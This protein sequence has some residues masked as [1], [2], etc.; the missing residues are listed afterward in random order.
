MRLRHLESL[1][2]FFHDVRLGVESLP[3]FFFFLG[4]E[5]ALDY[6]PH[7]PRCSLVRSKVKWS[8]RVP[9]LEEKQFCPPSYT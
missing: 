4:S 1:L 5:H 3:F 6:E 8:F 2:S 9:C 7:D